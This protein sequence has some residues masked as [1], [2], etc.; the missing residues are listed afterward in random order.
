MFDVAELPKLGQ[1]VA[2]RDLSL[3][4]DDD[5]LAAAVEVQAARASVEL[6]EARLLGEL[7]VRGVTARR[8]GL[9]TAPWVAAEAKVDRGGVARRMRLG[10]RLRRLP[11]VE[12][13]VATGA[14]SSDH[15][16]ALADAAANPRV[17]DQVEAAQAIWVELADTTSYA[18]WKRQLDHTVVQ[19]DQDG[20]YDPNRDLARNRLRLSPFPDGSLNVAGELVGEQALVVRQCIEAHA[21]RLFHRL[22]HDHDLCPELAV[23]THATLLAMAL[24]EL[25]LRGSTVDLDHSTGPATDVTLVVE[26][27][28]AVAVDPEVRVDPTGN[29]LLD[30]ACPATTPDGDHVHGEVAAMLLCDP[31]IT[32][33]VIETLGVP[34]DLG[35]TVRLANRRQRRAVGRR[36]GGCVFPGCDAPIGW[37]DVHHVVWWDRDGPTDI[38][39]LALLCRHHHGITHRRGWTMTTTGDHWFTWTT[40]LGQTLY[41]QRHRGRSPTRQLQPA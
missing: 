21:E 30:Q 33:L 38:W 26:A 28:P 22:R 5:L 3:L 27:T 35:R 12:A 1:Q 8:Y 11:L 15:A 34:L 13:A 16:V 36:D 31:V 39:N 6:Y 25:V 17:G 7:Q 10:Q 37:C 40:P 29:P 18:D 41:S 2:G 20:G 4:S 14:V 9:R 24:A 32:A 19:L 23:P